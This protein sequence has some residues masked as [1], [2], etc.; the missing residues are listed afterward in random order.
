[1]LR[2]VRNDGLRQ[3]STRF[4]VPAWTRFWATTRRLRDSDGVDVGK[5]PRI[6]RA[7]EAELVD[8]VFEQRHE[9]VLRKFE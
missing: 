4:L 9:C 8:S 1:M 7:N 2:D 6:V 3:D 5:C